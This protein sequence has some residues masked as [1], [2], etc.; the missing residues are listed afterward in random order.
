[1]VKMSL[2]CFLLR[3][4]PNEQFRRTCYIVMGLIAAYGISF[5]VATALQCWPASYAWEQIDSAVEGRCN[6]VHLQAWMAAI[7]NIAL[8]LILLVLPLRSLWALQMG[9]KKKLMIMSM[10]SLGLL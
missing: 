3:V 7:F 9:L 6:N 5:V 2:I 1:M 10:F 8:D 4:F